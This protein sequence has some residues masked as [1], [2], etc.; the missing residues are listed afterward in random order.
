V[1]VAKVVVIPDVP[2]P[3]TSPDRVI[4]SL[5]VLKTAIE[6]SD[7][8]KNNTPSAMLEPNSP[9][10]KSPLAATFETVLVDFGFIA[11][12]IFRRFHHQ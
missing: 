8:F 6:L 7:F 5:V 9:T 2:D 11:F 10:N 12:A 4:V 1:A 3:L